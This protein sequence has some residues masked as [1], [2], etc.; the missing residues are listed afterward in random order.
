MTIDNLDEAANGEDY[1]IEEMYPRFVREAEEDGRGD[2]V[3]VSS[4]LLN[5]RNITGQCSRKPSVP[6]RRSRA[7]DQS[8]C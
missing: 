4:L 1:E 5:V 7:E 3:P 6:S 8:T 2:A